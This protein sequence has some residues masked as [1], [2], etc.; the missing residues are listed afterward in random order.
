[1]LLRKQ[2]ANQDVKRT[3]ASRFT[4]YFVQDDA[5]DPVDAGQR[6]RRLAVQTPLD[7]GRLPQAERRRHPLQDSL[8]AA[9]A[10]AASAAAAAWRRRRRGLSLIHI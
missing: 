5:R 6:G 8:A 2:R 10:A 7:L 9:A 4:A 3:S 1:M